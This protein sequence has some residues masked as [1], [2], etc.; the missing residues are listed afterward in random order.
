VSSREK[1]LSGVSDVGSD[2][3]NNYVGLPDYVLRKALVVGNSGI[4]PRDVL[5]RDS[6]IQREISIE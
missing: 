6:Q 3:L 5:R 1:T 4:A 2:M